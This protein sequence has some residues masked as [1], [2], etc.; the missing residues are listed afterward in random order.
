MKMRLSTSAATPAPAA[1][2]ASSPA[3]IGRPDLLKTLGLDGEVG[4]QLRLFARRMVLAHNR[5]A[6]SG[7]YSLALRLA[8]ANPIA[9][10]AFREW[11][12]GRADTHAIPPSLRAWIDVAAH[13]QR[14]HRAPTEAALGGLYCP[15]SMRI[16]HGRG[17]RLRAG[18][19]SVNFVV[20]APWPWGGCP[21]S[22]RYGVRVGRYQLLAM[23]DDA[24]GYV[25]HFSWIARSSDAYRAEDIAAFLHQ[26]F[27][28]LG[29]WDSA[30]LERGSW[31]AHRIDELLKLS[32]TE[33]QTAYQPNQKLVEGWWNRAWTLLSNLPGQIGRFR[34]EEEAAASMVEKYRRGSLDPRKDLISL[35]DAANAVAR[36]VATL[37]ATRMDCGPM[38]G[39][40]V[41]AERWSSDLAERPLRQLP[42]S[43]EPLTRPERRE[44]MV[45]RMAIHCTAPCPTGD[46]L[47][48]EFYDE[49]LIP[50][51]GKQV[52]AYFDVQD[53]PCTAAIFTADGATLIAARATC[54][55]RAPALIHEASGYRLDWDDGQLERARMAKA[56]SRAAVRREHRTLAPDGKIEAW[57]SEVRDAK[58]RSV[59]SM[60]RSDGTA[61]TQP[62]TTTPAEST[63]A[64]LEHTPTAPRSQDRRRGATSAPATH[65]RAARPDPTDEDLAALERR[66]QQAGLIPSGYPPL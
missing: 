60:A 33:R 31:E 32:G 20:Y 62:L 59:A 57:S 9:P 42:A 51:E 49:A 61:A 5:T 52:L 11:V 24:T 4:E 12:A 22:D 2:A 41:P 43:T 63:A 39:S 38:W 56:A 6:D 14:H 8:A 37:N 3:P 26:P 58:S 45:R 29:C 44:L 36:V 7:S 23:H 19:G 53:D 17:D 1:A 46:A 10:A 40:W 16:H 48:Y 21:C 65:E 54:I 34:G 13:V 15:D 66:A 18:D 35:P 50:F 55:S 25:P 47:K 64:P 30:L 27:A 28:H